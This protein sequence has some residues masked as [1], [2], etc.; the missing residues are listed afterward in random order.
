MTNKV[1]IDASLA[2][3]WLLPQERIITADALILQWHTQGVKLITAPL[4]HAEV[5]SVIRQQVYFKKLH[6][7]EGELLFSLYL[8]LEIETVYEPVIYGQAWELAKKFNLPRT[9]DM[10]YLAVAEL[11]DCEL[12]TNDR[13]LVNSLQGKASQ[14][15]WAGEYETGL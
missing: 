11:R 15:K 2:L 10:Q 1:C 7:D 4:F 9:Y 5:T 6:P 8:Q 13:R 12:W 14:I 3:T